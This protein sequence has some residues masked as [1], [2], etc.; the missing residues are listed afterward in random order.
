[1]SMIVSV[2]TQ[3]VIQ[4]PIFVILIVGIVLAISRWERHPQVSL[5][6]LIGLGILLLQRLVGG[7]LNVWLPMRMTTGTMSVTSMGWLM[8]ARNLISALLAAVAYG[9][10]VTAIF[11]GRNSGAESEPSW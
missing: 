7:F 2:L 8:S 9:L 1:M 3:Y 10:I 5:L 4:I 11:R 6:A